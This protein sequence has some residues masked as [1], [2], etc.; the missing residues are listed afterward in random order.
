MY[1]YKNKVYVQIIKT[2]WK[3]MKTN[4]LKTNLLIQISRL[5]PFGGDYSEHFSFFSESHT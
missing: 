1:K 5:A 3:N 4:K 2:K